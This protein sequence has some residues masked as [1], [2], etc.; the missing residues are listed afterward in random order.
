MKV[1]RSRRDQRPRTTR[2][3]KVASRRWTVSAG[4]GGPPAM[5]VLPF[6]LGLYGFSAS[7]GRLR[8]TRFWRNFARAIASS[9]LSRRGSLVLA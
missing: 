9:F 3:G 4:A 2:K 6:R 1:V 8:S 5:I 7:V